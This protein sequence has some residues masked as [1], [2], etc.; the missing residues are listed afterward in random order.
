M[1]LLYAI[2]LKRRRERYR[3]GIKAL[4]DHMQGIV[5]LERTRRTEPGIWDIEGLRDLGSQ[6]GPRYQRGTQ[7]LRDPRAPVAPWVHSRN[8]E[9]SRERDIP[10]NEIENAMAREA[11]RLSRM[12]NF[13]VNS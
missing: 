11:R 13:L 9:D 1:A 8:R 12:Q 10:E 2:K 6:E 5:S 3:G 4:G 7:G